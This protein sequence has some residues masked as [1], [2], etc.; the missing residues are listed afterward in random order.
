MNF[1]EKLLQAAELERKMGVQLFEQIGITDYSFTP[2][3]GKDKHDGE[4]INSKGEKVTFEIKVRTVSSTHYDNHYID[5]AKINYLKQIPNSCVF[6]FFTDNK[7]FIH[8]IDPNREYPVKQVFANKNTTNSRFDKT[9][10]QLVEL[11]NTDGK[12]IDLIQNISV[13]Q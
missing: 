10:K 3:K 9:N 6:F 4:F 5:Q 12:L 2:A 7:V 1:P 8:R 11:Y 13:Y